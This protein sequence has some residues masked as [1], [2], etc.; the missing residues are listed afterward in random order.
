MVSQA[1][2][3][4]AAAHS[5]GLPKMNCSNA[6]AV[7]SG[8]SRNPMCPEFSSRTTCACGWAAII[9]SAASAGIYP[10]WQPRMNSCGTD[11]SRNS[12]L[13]SLRAIMPFS[14]AMIPSSSVMKTC[15][16]KS[17]T[18]SCIRRRFSGAKPA[19]FYYFLYL[20]LL[21]CYFLSYFLF[22]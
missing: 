4:V 3:S 7:A 15:S 1:R 11:D 13:R 9:A 21:F 10:S 14:R 18:S 6:C 2:V 12:S 16:V 17:S 22:F 19:V 8:S 20:Y 5:V